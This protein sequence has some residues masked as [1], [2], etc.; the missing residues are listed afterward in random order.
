LEVDASIFKS[1]EIDT[2][3]CL[4]DKIDYPHGDFYAG[5]FYGAE[6]IWMGEPVRLKRHAVPH[7]NLTG[8]E[9]MVVSSIQDLRPQLVPGAN[10]RTL[11]TDVAV[12]GD[13]YEFVSYPAST[14][15][16]PPIPQW[17]PPRLLLETKV[18][19]QV[20]SSSN[21]EKP[22]V[23]TW[24]CIHQGYTIKLEDI[25]GRWYE[26]SI[27]IP[28]LKS[29][30]IFQQSLSVGKWD[31]L[32]TQM[33]EM[34][35]AG[36]SLVRGWNRNARRSDDLVKAVP[37]EFVLGIDQQA[38]T[39]TPAPVPASNRQ[40]QHQQREMVDLT[41]EG[42]EYTSRTDQPTQAQVQGGTSGNAGTEIFME[43]GE[44]IDDAFTRQM[45]EDVESFL[46]SEPADS[47]YGGL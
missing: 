12:M 39:P 43:D 44:D 28:E 8:L 27:L 17:L 46:T 2:S 1:R 18:K 6:K 21:S 34:G 20:T 11:S 16:I 32:A 42:E 40:H 22:T 33:N 45:Q 24:N 13:I 36:Q 5:V 25:K 47:F 23:G 29:H 26:S 41:S 35:N 19:N 31:E 10:A 14:V 4:V 3:Y 15:P 7:A 38:P 30:S 9:I 37:S